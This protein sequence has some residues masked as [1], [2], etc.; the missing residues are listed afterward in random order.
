MKD[1]RDNLKMELTNKLL[2]VGRGD[3]RNFIVPSNGIDEC[4]LCNQ[5]SISMLRRELQAVV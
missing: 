1:I 4:K 2:L 3:C 5:F